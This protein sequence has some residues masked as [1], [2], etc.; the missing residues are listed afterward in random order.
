MTTKLTLIATIAV[1]SAVMAQPAFAYQCKTSPT[2]AVGIAAGKIVAQGKS[3]TNWTN[4]VKSSL[5]LAW[6]VWT[7]AKDR[8][9]DCTKLN[10]GQW[11]CLASA[12]PCLYV[13]P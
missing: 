4:N 10:S 1:A 5:G 2:Q 7:I 11:R 3:K 13:V 6:S 9:V 8:D 12:K